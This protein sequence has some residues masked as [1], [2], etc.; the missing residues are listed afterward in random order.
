MSAKILLRGSKGYYSK[1]IPVQI[2]STNE[3]VL[4]KVTELSEETANEFDELAARNLERMR[5]VGL[6]DL[7]RKVAPD[8]DAS[9]TSALERLFDVVADSRLTDPD[10][11]LIKMAREL[12]RE[13][14]AWM[15]RIVAEG[16][17]EFPPEVALVTEEGETHPEVVDIE[18][19]RRLP[20]WVREELERAILRETGLLESE[21]DFLAG[22]LLR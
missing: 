14:A 19:V 13:R 12:R 10:S 5:V 18:T 11:G 15:D 20:R 1:R 9:D 17:V 6:D 3:Q 22:L 21:A 8:G 16:L 4:F 7:F 2:P